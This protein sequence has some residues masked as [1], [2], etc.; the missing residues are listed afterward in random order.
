ME[1]FNRGCYCMLYQIIFNYLFFFNKSTV[2]LLESVFCYLTLVGCITAID[3]HFKRTFLLLCFKYEQKRNVQSYSILFPLLL[4]FNILISVE[5]SFF[6]CVCKIACCLS[7][8]KRSQIC[9]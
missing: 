8:I 7:L 3:L 1:V 5:N 2:C 6:L 4:Y 9:S